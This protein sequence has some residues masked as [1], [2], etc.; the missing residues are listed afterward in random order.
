MVRDGKPSTP[1]NG[2]AGGA[3]MAR[4]WSGAGRKMVRRWS[5]TRRS[6][7]D[8]S[9]MASRRYL[10]T[11]PFFASLWT[12][13]TCLFGLRAGCCVDTVSALAKLS[14][15]PLPSLSPSARTIFLAK[16]SFSASTSAPRAAAS[17]A[18]ETGETIKVQEASGIL[19]A[20]W[21]AAVHTR[22]LRGLKLAEA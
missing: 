15:P 11:R 21:C 22:R 5:D 19:S 9:A 18:S 3:P 10:R 4:A 8:I 2:F 20:N 16:S 12:L 7:G 1:R 6:D 14:L 13:L 17:C